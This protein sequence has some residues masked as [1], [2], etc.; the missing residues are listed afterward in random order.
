MLFIIIFQAIKNEG[1]KLKCTK[2]HNA[3]FELS[4]QQQMQREEKK[5]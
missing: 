2:L 1:K 3:T 4:W 5:N